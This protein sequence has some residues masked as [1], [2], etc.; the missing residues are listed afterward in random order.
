MS[1]LISR[2]SGVS[3]KPSNIST[4]SPKLRIYALVFPSFADDKILY[5]SDD[6][7]KRIT[8]ESLEIAL[9]KKSLNQ[10]EGTHLSSAWLLLY[11]KEGEANLTSLKGQSCTTLTPPTR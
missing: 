2:S 7:H 11:R 9:I 1:R 3:V 5:Q 10:E 8:R 6:W 4:R